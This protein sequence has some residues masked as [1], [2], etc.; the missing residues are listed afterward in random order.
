MLD[1]G[2]RLPG[3]AQ[4]KGGG[5]RSFSAFPH[6]VPML[7]CC[8]TPRLCSEAASATQITCL[9]REAEGQLW[10][11]GLKD[12][13]VRG[14]EKTERKDRREEERERGRDRERKAESDRIE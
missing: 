10:V 3:V 4:G 14:R 7:L 1:F 11:W 9:I 6:M 2:E 5:E 8:P 13:Q 12:K